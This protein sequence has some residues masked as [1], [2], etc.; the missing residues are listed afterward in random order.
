MNVYLLRT[1]TGQ[2]VFYANGR[3]DGEVEESP[4]ESEGRQGALRAVGRRYTAMQKLLKE[5]ER[6]VGLRMRRMWEWLDRRT[7]PDE[8]WLRALRTASHVELFYPADKFTEEEARTLWRKYLADRSRRH[9][10]WFVMNFVIA[11]LT[12]VLALVPGPNLIGYWFTYRA[13]C[14]VLVLLGIRSG[15]QSAARFEPSTMLSVPLGGGGD[16]EHMARIEQHFGLKDL[17][18]YVH[19]TVGDRATE[20]PNTKLAVS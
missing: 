13:L 15:K 16:A 11:P 6:G 18:V 9:A 3:K 10:F 2:T 5:S 14:H 12:L 7:S 17:G 8:G 1:S 20:A 19:R 4:V